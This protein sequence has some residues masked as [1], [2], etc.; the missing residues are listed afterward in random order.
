MVSSDLS[1]T[2][3]CLI[4]YMMNST[5]KYNNTIVTL[6]VLHEIGRRVR[7]CTRLDDVWNMPEGER[8]ICEFNEQCQP[9]KAE[10]RLLTRF[11]GTVVRK[12]N[13]APLDVKGWLQMPK[14]KKDEM[15]KI[16]EV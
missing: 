4:S 14:E 11:I 15:C 1:V 2:K 8:I 7:G 9:I 13:L 6:V 3:L 5:K 12:P 16:V 10:G